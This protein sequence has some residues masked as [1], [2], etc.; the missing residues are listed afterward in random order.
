MVRHATANRGRLI[1]PNAARVKL[2][3]SSPP[4]LQ[5]YAPCM[6]KPLDRAEATNCL[7]ALSSGDDTAH[8]RLLSLVYTEL[9]EKAAAYL[10]GETP[11]HTL[12]PTALVH[13]AWFRLIDQDRVEWKNEDILASISLSTDVLGES[14]IA[15]NWPTVSP[16]TML[17]AQYLILDAAATA[18]V[19]F[20]NALALEGH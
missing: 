2:G 4:G 17:Y 3:A 16:G 10:S 6:E 1:T 7:R 20:S 9:R 14:H 19:S 13:E 11:G 5:C 8:D 15:F 12:Q 18:S